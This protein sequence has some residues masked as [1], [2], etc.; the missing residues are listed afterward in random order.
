LFIVVLWI[1]EPIVSPWLEA[2]AE[3]A[4]LLAQMETE[5]AQEDRRSRAQSSQSTGLSEYQKCRLEYIGRR[6][7]KVDRMSDHQKYEMEAALSADYPYGCGG[8]S[9]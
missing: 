8:L 2:R 7:L 6:N 9:K 4:K 5:R 3:R 1:T